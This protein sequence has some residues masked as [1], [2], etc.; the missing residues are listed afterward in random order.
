MIKFFRRIRQQLLSEGNTGRYLKYA[1][2]EILLVMIGILLALQVNN[3]DEERKGIIKEKSYLNSIYTELKEDV[4]KIEGN[5]NLLTKHYSIGLEVL[6]AIDNNDST[7]IDSTKIATYLG[8][9]L[10]QIIPVDREE[11]TWDK[12]KVL[13]YNTF[14]IDDSLTIQL[15]KFYSKY[16]QQIERFNQL[17]KKLRQ[18]LR[19]LTGHCHYAEGLEVMRKKGITFYGASSPKTRKCILSISKI[20]ELVGAIMVTCIVNTKIYEELEAE[21]DNLLSQMKGQYEFITP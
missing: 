13:G 17:P 12:F 14:I 3:W 11:N 4:A 1:I 2:G 10:S 9:N 20:R 15:N 7:T 8:W 6:Q 5:W 21:A 18:E 16:D 19:E